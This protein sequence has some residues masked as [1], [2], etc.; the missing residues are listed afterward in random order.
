MSCG[1][2]PTIFEFDSK[3]QKRSRY[4]AKS[5]S[6]LRTKTQLNLAKLKF[7]MEYDMQVAS[8]SKYLANPLQ[9]IGLVVSQ[10]KNTKSFSLCEINDLSTAKKPHRF[11]RNNY[12]DHSK[13]QGSPIN[14]RQTSIKFIKQFG[15]AKPKENKS[16][17]SIVN[18]L[19]NYSPIKEYNA[20][21]ST[22][23]TY[24]HIKQALPEKFRCSEIS[25][26]HALDR[27][28]D[29]IETSRNPE[30]PRNFEISQNCACVQTDDLEF[31]S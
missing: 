21:M 24:R 15:E 3:C 13:N 16:L 11:T 19:W 8:Q 4:P 2:R 26:K 25:S 9:N 12:F 29:N 6:H 28:T 17:K 31:N 30:I 23:R 10:P 1:L 14:L 22:W 7:S 5:P 20:T 18:D 27:N